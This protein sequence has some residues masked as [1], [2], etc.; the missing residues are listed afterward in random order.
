MSNETRTHEPTPD[1]SPLE[2]CTPVSLQWSSELHVAIVSGP[3]TAGE[4]WRNVLDA[5]LYFIAGYD[6]DSGHIVGYFGQSSALKAGR[7]YTSMTH[8]IAQERRFVARRIALVRFTKPPTSRQ[9]RLIE[10]RV[11][12]ALSAA[13]IH[14]YNRHTSAGLAASKLSRSQRVDALRYAEDLFNAI[15]RFVIEGRRNSSLLPAPNTREAAVRVLLRARRAL[16]TNEVCQLLLETGWETTGS[17]FDRSVRRDLHDRERK[18]PGTPRVFTML[19]R[20]HRVYWPPTITK[21]QALAGYDVAHPRPRAR[22][23]T[24]HPEQPARRT[25]S[26]STAPTPSTPWGA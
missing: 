13:G 24:A 25:V 15:D 9:L 21:A 12:M 5:N 11:I 23:R 19:H 10:S 6:I 26:P 3:M 18:T 1:L 2:W 7:P 8:W 14:L 4:R 17:T 22:T 16:S 20:D